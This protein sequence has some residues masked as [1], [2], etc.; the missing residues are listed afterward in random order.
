MGFVLGF[1]PWD[2]A[3]GVGMPIGKHLGF[4]LTDLFD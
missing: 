2:L 3:S 4:F 1:E